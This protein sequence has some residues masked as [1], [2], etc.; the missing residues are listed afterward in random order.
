MGEDPTNREGQE[1]ERGQHVFEQL[2][3]QESI[4]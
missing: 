3:I 2:L 4:H 1:N